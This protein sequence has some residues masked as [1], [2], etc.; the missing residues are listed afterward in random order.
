MRTFLMKISLP[1]VKAVIE[2]LGI[3]AIVYSLILVRE[4][5]VQNQQL[6]EIN[7]EMTITQN[8]MMANQT[9][10]KHPDIWLRGC[11]NDSLSNQ[12]M[13]VFKAMIDDWNTLTFYNAGRGYRLNQTWLSSIYLTDFAGFL[14]ENPGARKVWKQYEEKKIS[15]RKVLG[16]ITAD[17]WYA[18]VTKT[19]EK[20]DGMGPQ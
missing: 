18:E 9:I 8:R 10:T 14:H 19:L 16:S 1:K 2:I 6:A 13:V 7:Y 17:F 15:D 3:V 12:E 4:E 11:A 20:L 5:I